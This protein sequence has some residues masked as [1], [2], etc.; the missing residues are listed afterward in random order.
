MGDFQDVFGAGADAVDII[1]GF[2]RQYLREQR[3]NAFEARAARRHDNSDNAWLAT[4]LAGGY[5]KGP[6]FESYDALACWERAE[7]PR[8]HI[9]KP[10]NGGYQVFFTN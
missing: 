6:F 2:N 10:L 7:A 3:A 1:E 8:P 9:R 5:R 4:M